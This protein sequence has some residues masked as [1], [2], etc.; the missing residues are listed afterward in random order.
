M[1]MP[2]CSPLTAVVPFA[3]L[4]T[5]SFFVLFALRKVEE[6]WLR[7]FGYVVAGLLC[8]AAL[9]VF[10]GTPYSMGRGPAKMKYMMRQNMGGM[11]GM[12]QRDNMPG[13]SMSG[14]EV[15]PKGRKLP[16]SKCGGNKGVIFKTE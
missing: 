13:M 16:A 15:S 7:G 12:M 8:F 10:L 11:P 2:R 5:L 1:Y 4:L 14:K 9:V 6:K 3:L